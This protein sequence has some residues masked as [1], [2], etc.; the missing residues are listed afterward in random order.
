MMP[1]QQQNPM[2]IGLPPVLT[3]LTMSVFRPIA[4]IA[5]TIKNLLSSLIGE[6]TLAFTPMETAIV[7]ITDAAT[8][9][10]IKKGKICFKLTFFS[11]FTALFLVPCTNQRQHKSNRNNCQGSGELH[12]NGS[13]QRGRSEVP[14]TVHVE[15]AA[16]TEEV[17]FTAVLS[18]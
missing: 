13:I 18:A 3:S 12:G 17:S 16:V 11:G 7:V 2:T 15:A 8:K 1:V 10:S 14:H 5:S 9:Y 4:A 6:N